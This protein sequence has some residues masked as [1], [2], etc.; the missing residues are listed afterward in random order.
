MKG[1][2]LTSLAALGYTY[3]GYPLLIE[4]L[5]R[6]APT[7]V[8]RDAGY[9]PTVSLL[10][11]VYNARR[12]VEPKLQSLVEQDY[13]ADKVQVLLYSDASDDGSDA[14]VL[15]FADAARASGYRGEIRLIRGDVRK[16]KPT[17]LNEMRVAATGEVFVLTDIRQPL[18]K[19]AV[20][21]L[22]SCLADPSV[23]AVSGNLI[24]VGGTG[25]GFYWH[26]EN[27][28]RRAEGRFRSMIGVTGPLY[29]MRAADFG[30]VPTD[31]I[32]DDM[33]IP[34]RLRLAGKRLVQ[35]EEAQAYDEAFED[36][37]ELGR[38]VRTLAGNFQLF[39]RMPELLSPV[40]NPIWFETFSHKV[41]RLA[42]PALMAT[43][44]ASS[45]A[46]LTRRPD[47][48]L[49]RAVVAGQVAFGVLSALGPRAGK[50]GSTARTFTVLNYAAVMGFLRHLQGAQK[51][52]W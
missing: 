9:E 38:K 47:D 13:P 20:R 44:F 7:E 37:R 43:A 39:A 41:L 28:M 15:A 24:L 19:N 5:S 1:L 21:S 49:L 40:D 14:A 34:L 26:Y 12:Y 8:L 4:A 52:T 29:A 48:A 50:L 42:G 11:P 27:R 46:A 22:V 18:S 16:G 25:A 10:I 2:A 32:L 31:I 35:C 17:A 6:L 3:A 51:V 45:V 23:G 36:D 33:W 30:E